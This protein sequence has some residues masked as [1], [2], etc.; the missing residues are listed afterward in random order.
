MGSVLAYL[1]RISV[2]GYEILMLFVFPLP[3]LLALEACKILWGDL[4]MRELE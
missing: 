2:A 4:T 3:C 1:N